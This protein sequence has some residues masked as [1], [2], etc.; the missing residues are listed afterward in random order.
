LNTKHTFQQTKIKYE[1][2]VENRPKDIVT[3]DFIHAI[4]T[5]L[6][7]SMRNTFIV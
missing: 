1:F 7:C 5:L 2:A 6:R 3:F 4:Q